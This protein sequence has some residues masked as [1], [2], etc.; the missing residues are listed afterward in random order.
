MLSRSRMQ[1]RTS[2][3]VDNLTQEEQDA[4]SDVVR[5]FSLGDHF[6][7]FAQSSNNRTK[8]SID[9]LESFLLTTNKRIAFMKNSISKY[10]LSNHQE[11][12]D[13]ADQFLRDSKSVM[14]LVGIMSEHLK[15][16]KELENQ[17][18]KKAQM[19][20]EKY[21]DIQKKYNG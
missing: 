16:L 21:D 8:N 17:I 11:V 12:I 13:D 7:L 4:I 2:A 18:A 14:N 1:R 20:T 3:Y 19:M 9:N 15:D 10:D 5:F 6:L